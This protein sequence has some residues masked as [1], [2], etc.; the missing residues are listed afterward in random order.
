MLFLPPSSSAKTTKVH[1]QMKKGVTKNLKIIDLGL[2][3]YVS[4]KKNHCICTCAIATNEKMEMADVEI[5]LVQV[6][7]QASLFAHTGGYYVN[8]FSSV[9]S[10]RAG[11]II[12]TL[13]GTLLLMPRH[14]IV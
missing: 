7:I 10:G 14:A 12:Q 8:S 3:F 1:S 5:V 11:I 13:H 4:Y 2:Y 6:Q 9:H